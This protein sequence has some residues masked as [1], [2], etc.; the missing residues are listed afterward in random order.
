MSKNK[1]KKF[2]RPVE[3]PELALFAI[4]YLSFASFYISFLIFPYSIWIVYVIFYAILIIPII[5]F[6]YFAGKKIAIY[7]Q[8][9]K[10]CGGVAKYMFALIVINTCLSV[11][12]FIL[13]HGL[14]ARVCETNC[15]ELSIFGATLRA[16]I[17]SAV[18][19]VPGLFAA[20]RKYNVKAIKN[21][22]ISS[23]VKKVSRKKKE[24]DSD[25]F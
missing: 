5:I 20:L 7:C 4:L 8:S 10:K 13:Y 15:Y 21:K 12:I 3:Y 22:S 25:E 16:F 14:P 24:E 9:M 1:N 11:L 2:V 19:I 17:A 6:S 18:C 23:K